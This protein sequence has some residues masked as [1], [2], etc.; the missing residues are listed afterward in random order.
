MLLDSGVPAVCALGALIS[1]VGVAAMAFPGRPE[2][3]PV[4]LLRRA[5]A[6][7]A[8]AAGAVYSLGFFAVLTADLA[9]GDG[10]DS[11]PATACREGFDADTVRGLSHSRYSL[12]PLRFDCVRD[13]GSVYSS[14]PDYVWMNWGALA[15]ALSAVLLAVA[16][17]CA[18]EFR[19][20]KAAVTP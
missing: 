17:G 9:V 20:R 11:T 12:L 10:A 4:H 3:W 16:A 2:P 19:A 13:D 18:A 1:A 5:A 14:D 8:C 7:A 15:L 6:M